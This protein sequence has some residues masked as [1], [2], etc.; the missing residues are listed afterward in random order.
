MPGSQNGFDNSGRRTS[1]PFW[2]DTTETVNVTTYVT[3]YVL[4]KYGTNKQVDSIEMVND[5]II[6]C[7]GLD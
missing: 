1:N 5:I 4:A 3:N 6:K 2:L 7:T